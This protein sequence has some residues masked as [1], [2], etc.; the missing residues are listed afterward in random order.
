[1]GACRRKAAGE[2]QWQLAIPCA[3]GDEALSMP[4]RPAAYPCIAQL[5]RRNFLVR[6][7][8]LMLQRRL[9]VLLLPLRIRWHLFDRRRR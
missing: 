5:H 2:T 4:H 9:Q 1:M 8:L 6:R 3:G 7:Q